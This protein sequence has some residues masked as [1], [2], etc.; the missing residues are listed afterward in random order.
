MEVSTQKEG[1]EQPRV[2][3]IEG[4]N[5]PCQRP[6]RTAYTAHGEPLH[7]QSMPSLSRHR[8]MAIGQQGSGFCVCHAR[9]SICSVVPHTEQPS[10]SGC[11]ESRRVNIASA[12]C[13]EFLALSTIRTWVAGLIENLVRLPGAEGVRESERATV[14]LPDMVIIGPRCDPV[15]KQARKFGTEVAGQSTTQ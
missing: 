7:S 11:H 15:C 10:S 1:V 2:L 6:M 4:E 14:P 3:N 12:G 13:S 5:T 9:P 8:T